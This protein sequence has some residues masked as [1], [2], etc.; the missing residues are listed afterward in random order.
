MFVPVDELGFFYGEASPEDETYAGRFFADGGDNGIGKVF[1]SERTMTPG[2]V[3]I[4]GEDAVQ[5]QNA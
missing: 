2:G 4:N 1:P 3:G 5:E